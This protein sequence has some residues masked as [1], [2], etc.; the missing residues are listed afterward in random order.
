M[1]N[2]ILIT[3][4]D[5]SSNYYAVCEYDDYLLCAHST[6]SVLAKNIGCGLTELKYSIIKKQSQFSCVFNGEKII[7]SN[8]DFEI[9]ITTSLLENLSEW[10]DFEDLDH[11]YYERLVIHGAHDDNTA[12]PF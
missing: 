9:D 3:P 12:E 6:A 1:N 4:K 7:A 10:H 2:I 11:H 5:Q 8:S